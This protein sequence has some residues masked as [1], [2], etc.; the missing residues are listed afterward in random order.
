MPSSKFVSAANETSLIRSH[1]HVHTAKEKTFQGRKFQPNQ[2]DLPWTRQ[3]QFSKI[4]ASFPRYLYLF[5]T[6]QTFIFSSTTLGL[7]FC[8]RGCGR[9][10]G[11]S[12][13]ELR[14]CH[15]CGLA[16]AG[17]AVRFGGHLG[18]RLGGKGFLLLVP[19]CIDIYK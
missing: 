16:E 1:E 19:G 18:W 12:L 8:C 15:G 5:R 7:D 10:G 17:G 6:L 9:P 13:R 11:P 3:G 14:G 4:I 2:S